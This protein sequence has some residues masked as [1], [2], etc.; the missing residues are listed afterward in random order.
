MIMTVEE[1]RKYITTEETDEMLKLKLD[2]I[3]QMILNYTNNN[4]HEFILAGE[5]VYPPDIKIGVIGLMKWELTNRDKV[6]IASE[7]IS[8]HSVTY[9]DANGDSY[10]NGYPKALMS[11]L[12]GYRKARF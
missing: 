8:R 12:K 11:F 4:F 2:A 9:A 7:T 10:L 3:E 5:V 1:L 6:G